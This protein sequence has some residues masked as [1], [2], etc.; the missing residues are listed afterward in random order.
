MCRHKLG[1]TVAGGFSLDEAVGV[2][3]VDGAPVGGLDQW[4]GPGRK[5]AALREIGVAAVLGGQRGGGGALRRDGRGRGRLGP[6][7]MRLDRNQQPR[8][9]G[10]A[11][12]PCTMTH[13]PTSPLPFCAKL[14]AD[15]RVAAR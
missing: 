14:C 13:D 4:I 6:L 11:P 8:R 7:G 15:P 10:T 3:V 9:G 12:H 1:L 5:E 2:E